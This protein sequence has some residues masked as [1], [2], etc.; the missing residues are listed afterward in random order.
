MQIEFIKVKSSDEHLSFLYDRL[1]NRVHSISHK[2]L[3]DFEEHK[4]FVENHPYRYW[5]LVKIRGKFLGSIYLQNDN[6]VGIDIENQHYNKYLSS[7]LKSIK[8]KIKPLPE[9]KSVRPNFFFVN[10]STKNKDLILALEKIGGKEVQ[11]SF[12]LEK[13]K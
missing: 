8:S 2:R 4:S 12:A 1:K 11:K 7:I 9:V 6:S 5:F 3:P 10:V 13:L